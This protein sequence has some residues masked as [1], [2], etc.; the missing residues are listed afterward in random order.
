M[1]SGFVG[2]AKLFRIGI[3]ITFNY[4]DT[5][6]LLSFTVF[7]LFS[8]CIVLICGVPSIVIKAHKSIERSKY[9]DEITGQKMRNATYIYSQDLQGAMDRPTLFPTMCSY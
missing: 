4:M 7:L 2:N 9:L 1:F 3:E 5:T 8:V 6:T